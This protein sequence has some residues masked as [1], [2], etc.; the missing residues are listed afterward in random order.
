MLSEPH[1]DSIQ[2]LEADM[3]LS[4]R[5]REAIRTGI[6]SGQLVAGTLHS[7]T[8]LAERFGISRTPVREALIELSKQGMVRF[9][10]NRGVRIL[11][12]SVH[13]LEE[14]VEIRLLLEPPAIYRA[15]GKIDADTIGQLEDELI[16]MAHA[17]ESADFVA[18]MRHDRRFHSLILG[19]SGNE[20][21]QGFIDQLRDLIVS[22]GNSTLGASR[23]A[24]EIL[25]EHRAI[26]D[27][28]AAGDALA[29]ATSM[30]DHIERTGRLLVT[31][32]GGSIELLDITQRYVADTADSP[33]RPD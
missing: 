1:V 3:P 33:G 26:L 14:I 29:A 7:V 4:A 21:L 19:Q 18:F 11:E 9:E 17:A 20:R 25:A 32:E 2:R 15:V 27:H 5:A 23:S 13:D 28:I 6:L 12:P 31:Q 16:E 8:A 30:H 10:R 22:R 24:Q